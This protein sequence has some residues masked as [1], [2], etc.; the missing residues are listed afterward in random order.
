MS[1]AY[2]EVS[3]SI[4]PLDPAREILIA[5][6][7]QLP[8]ESF[9]ETENGLKAYI[10]EADFDIAS[11]QE[12]NILTFGKSQ[13]DYVT[14]II[15][16]ENWNAKWEA[17]FDPILVDGLCLVRAPFHETQDVAYEIVIMPKMSFGTGHHE[18]TFLMIRQMLQ[19]DLIGKNVLDMGC[20]T[21][22]LA[23]LACKMGAKKVRA[24]DI[25]EWSYTNSFENAKSNDCNGIEIEQGDVELLKGPESY[26]IILAN[27]NR[28]VLLSDIPNYVNRLNKDGLLLLSGFFTEDLEQITSVC[29]KTGLRLENFQEKNNW[30][31]AKY[32]F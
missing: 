1:A 5:E 3:F 6:L 28:N 30:V 18:T 7:S 14:R 20:G 13:I 11:L 15:P 9:L 24:I 26:D 25:D 32:V 17:D 22:V 10:R 21:G 12:L 27:I 4:R 8:Y 31:S 29:A 23:I 19:L 2:R 16:E